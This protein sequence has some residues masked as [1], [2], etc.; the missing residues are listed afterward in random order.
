L[1]LRPK[2]FSAHVWRFPVRDVAASV[3]LLCYRSL[4]KNKE[5]PMAMLRLP[6]WFVTEGKRKV[7]PAHQPCDDPHA[8]LAFTDTSTVA[9][10]M[11]A[12]QAGQWKIDLVSDT[13]E[14]V[15]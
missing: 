7:P 8:V 6:L 11:R 12:G 4:L 14:L 10:L 13:A 5:S 3:D 15:P 1:L 2:S 9:E